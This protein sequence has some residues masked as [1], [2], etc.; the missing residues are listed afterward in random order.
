MQAG[1]TIRKVVVHP[2]ESLDPQKTGGVLYECNC[3]QCGQLYVGEMEIFL[4]EKSH[5]HGKSVKE[6]D[7]QSA[8][9]QHQVK[10]GHM[11]KSNE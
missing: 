9:G 4:G 5:E 11:V 10:S 2:N 8:L 3:E 7:S 1:Y 6:S